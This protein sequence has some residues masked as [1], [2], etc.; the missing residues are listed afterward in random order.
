MEDMQSSNIVKLTKCICEPYV[1]INV[2]FIFKV[3]LLQ[4]IHVIMHN[5]V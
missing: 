4:Y 3:P 2:E 1:S 5:T